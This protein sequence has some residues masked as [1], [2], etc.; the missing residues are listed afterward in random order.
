M[1]RPAP[2]PRTQLPGRQAPRVLLIS[3]QLPLPQRVIRVLHRQRIPV[4]RLSRA[5]RRVRPAQIP[6]QRP[7]RPAVPG[8][9]MQHQQQYMLRRAQHEQPRPDRQLRGQVEPAAA[10]AASAAGSSCS[11]APPPAALAPPPGRP[12]PAATARRPPRET[13]SARSRAC[14]PHPPAPAPAPPGPADRSTAPPAE[15][16][17]SPR[18]PSSRFR[19]HSRC[20]ADDNGT[21]SGRSRA[22]SGGRT[23]RPVRGQHRREPRDR[24]RL[25]QRGQVQFAASSART[26]LSSRV[27]QQRVTAQV[28]E[29]VIDADLLDPQ[30]LGEQPRQ[31]LLARRSRRPYSVAAVVA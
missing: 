5:P 29:A 23:G 7:H 28:E 22:T 14:S 11:S 3:Q 2:R 17:R 10:A 8:D 26:R 20:C 1:P 24:S 6:A 18:C 15:C 9:V 13:P 4:R 30:H 27:R 31:D 12:S 16:C 25:E 19:N 21:R